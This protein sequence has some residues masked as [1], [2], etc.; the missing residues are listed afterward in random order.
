MGTLR[1]L[2]YRDWR[3]ASWRQAKSKR[4]VW[5][6]AGLHLDVEAARSATKGMLPEHA[7]R[8][9]GIQMDAVPSARDLFKWGLAEDEL[10]EGG[11][12]EADMTHRCFRCPLLQHVRDK[13]QHQQVIQRFERA[14]EEQRC[15]AIFKSALPTQTEAEE[16]MMDAL[17]QVETPRIQLDSGY[18]GPLD[19]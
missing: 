16:E 8:I 18:N 3:Q 14:T 2:L 19:V 4:K 15:N 1:A 6:G 9:E 10:C 13:C 7:G 17:W 11:A 5:R 12:V